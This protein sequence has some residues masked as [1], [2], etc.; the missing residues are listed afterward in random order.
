MNKL[1]K[2]LQSKITLAVFTSIVLT[3][4]MSL[5]HSVIVSGLCSFVTGV[6]YAWRVIDSYWK[7]KAD[8]INKEFEELKQKYYR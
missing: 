7:N 2:F 3:L 4:I 1:K 6:F 5:S 8:N